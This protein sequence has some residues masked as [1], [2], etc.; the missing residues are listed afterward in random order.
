LQAEGRRFESVNAHK[1]THKYL[2]YESFFYAHAA[3]TA[4]TSPFRER[5]RQPH[6]DKKEIP[7]NEIY[8]FFVTRHH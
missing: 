1:K 5:E 4:R 7:T 2:A 3:G 6:E 8:I